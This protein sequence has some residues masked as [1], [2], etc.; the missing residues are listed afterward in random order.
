L[1]DH[2]ESRPR[3]SRARRLALA[4][5]A[6]GLALAARAYAPVAARRWINFHSKDIAGYGLHV[7]DIDL[8]LWRM[9]YALDGVSLG[10]AS[11]DVRQPLFSVRRLTSTLRWRDALRHPLTADMEAI[12]PRITLV[13]GPDSARSQYGIDLAWRRVLRR[14]A[15]MRVG[16]IE[17]RDAEIRFR[18]TQASPRVDLSARNVDLF[19]DNLMRGGSS[20]ASHRSEWFARGRLQ[21]SG[22][23]V[24]R[25]RLDP[26]ER[27]PDFVMDFALRGLDLRD[28]N[29]AL[30]AYAGVDAEKGWLDMSVHVVASGGRYRGKIRSSLRGLDM[31][32]PEEKDRGLAGTLKE[33]AAQLAGDLFEAFAEERKSKG[34]KPPGISISGRFPAS[35]QDAWSMSGYVLRE[36]FRSA[37]GRGE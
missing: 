7:S 9:G 4:A 14:M 28:C 29:A 25:M 35:A 16:R 30:K 18:D 36:S 5:A 21:G 6:A 8:R 12:G 33:G 20:G 32:G 27:K 15:F 19:A 10:K 37:L 24:L 17:M 34:E 31:G 22:R 2:A 23:F 11:G 13:H 1:E 26:E 3:R